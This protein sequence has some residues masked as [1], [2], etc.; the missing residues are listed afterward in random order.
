MI[1]QIV[2]I[3][4]KKNPD[5][6]ISKKLSSARTNTDVILTGVLSPHALFVATERAKQAKFIRIATNASN[7]ESIKIFPVLIHY[8][9]KKGLVLKIIDI[10]NLKNKKFETIAMYLTEFLNKTVLK[11]VTITLEKHG[12]GTSNVF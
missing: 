5:A 4:F 6:S 1:V 3:N 10:N 7:H 12:A 9:T 8:F 2:Q 11:N